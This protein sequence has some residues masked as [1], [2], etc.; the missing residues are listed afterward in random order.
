MKSFL[1][2]INIQL[3]S[4]AALVVIFP[5]FT[6]SV[7]LAWGQDETGNIDNE[8]F[9]WSLESMPKP[10]EGG[11]KALMDMPLRG[12]ESD[13][14]SSPIIRLWQGRRTNI[15]EEGPKED[16]TSVKPKEVTH[17]HI[18]PLPF[19]GH[20]QG[21]AGDAYSIEVQKNLEGP[22][23]RTLVALNQTEP[24]LAAGVFQAEQIGSN[25]EN[26]AY[27]AYDMFNNQLYESEFVKRTTMAAFNS[28][29][30]KETKGE[31]GGGGK[32]WV[33]ALARC[34]GEPNH[35]EPIKDN[36]K[37][38]AEHMQG[39][40]IFIAKKHT[41]RD[42]ENSQDVGSLKL[43]P[44]TISVTSV[45][46]NYDNKD[47][48]NTKDNIN[49]VAEA[50]LKW[51]GD[52]RIVFEDEEGGSNGVDHVGRVFKEEYIE[53][54]EDIYS[55]AT[56][57]IKDRFKDFMKVQNYYC[58]AVEGVP[59]GTVGLDDSNAPFHKNK[60]NKDKE[61]KKAIWRLSVPEKPFQEFITTSI[62][63]VYR[64]KKLADKGS[65]ENIC[66]TLKNAKLEDADPNTAQGEILVFAYKYANFVAISQIIR[67][68]QEAHEYVNKRTGGVNDSGE[69]LANYAHTLITKAIGI[70]DLSGALVSNLD[71]WNKLI[72]QMR[73]RASK[74]S[75]Y[76]MRRVT[77]W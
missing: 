64:T 59:E 10:Y 5:P 17:H 58:N 47:Q 8:F 26:A 19:L 35:N 61:V 72:E 56:V 7:P 12:A 62:H 16:N 28:C 31:G 15:K 6:F 32:S 68:A 37:V 42:G 38:N 63:S 27:Q 75:G 60:L 24:A 48:G 74:H 11:E 33:V 22:F 66:E 34:M 14:I 69:V 73:L 49:D 65:S 70:N 1:K 18:S 20:R 55:I 29:M 13:T 54:E 21:M 36:E 30:Y 52:Y 57:A 67:A 2:I 76:A 53:P 23:I 3:L 25:K 43:E 41:S 50:W 77:G 40:N 45:L 71:S 9:K 39:G 44:N 46:F 51:F 4:I